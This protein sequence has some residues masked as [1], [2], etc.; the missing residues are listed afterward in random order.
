M[1]LHNEVA[2]DVVVSEGTLPATVTIAGIRKGVSQ[3]NDQIPLEIVRRGL[4][5]P[6]LAPVEL[7]LYLLRTCVMLWYS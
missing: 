1:H 3:M 7:S 4:K 2:R 6:V 5:R